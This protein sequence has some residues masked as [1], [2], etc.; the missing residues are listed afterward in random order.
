MHVS[1]FSFLTDLGVCKKKN[2]PES[3]FEF[4]DRCMKTFRCFRFC[5]GWINKQETHSSVSTDIKAVLGTLT[6]E[7]LQTVVREHTPTPLTLHKW[8]L[9]IYI[10][11]KNVLD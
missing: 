8:D 4:R 1:Y 10:Y 11:D 7:S 6:T 9:Q 2:L 5:T 3:V